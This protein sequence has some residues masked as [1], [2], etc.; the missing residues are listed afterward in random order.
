MIKFILSFIG[1]FSFEYLYLK[2]ANKYN[3]I[4]KPNSRSSHTRP[5]I[6]G[7]GIVFIISLIVWEVNT[8]FKFPWLFASI[9]LS[10][11]VSFVDDI[12]GLPSKVRFLAHFISVTLLLFQTNLLVLD[13]WLFP[14]FIVLIGI[15]NAYNFMDGIN[16][17]T[18]FYS[19]AV[20]IPFWIIETN[21][22]LKDY[23]T[24]A[25]ISIL[26]FLYFNARKNAICF[27]GDIGSISMAI[28]VLYLVLTK[29][30][31]TGRLELICVLFIY[32]LDSIFTILQRIIKKENIFIA[33]RKH[34]YQILANEFKIRHLYVSFSYALIQ[35]LFN[36]WLIIYPSSNILVFT[37]VTIFG[38]TY[39]A[40]KY[41]LLKRISVEKL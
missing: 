14:L 40:L 6:R 12:K 29:I 3:I 1:F 33:H 39:V 22:V 11:I 21:V 28:M 38:I 10:G 18:G 7:G 15:K 2:L 23:S 32:G 4:D 25:I 34:L 5:I 8:G 41:Q 37:V 24:F 30:V 13:W 16:G 26:V 31:E 35:F 17:I 27:A 36:L 20:F 9:L 19:L